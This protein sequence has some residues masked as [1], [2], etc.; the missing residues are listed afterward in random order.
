MQQPAKVLKALGDETRLRILKLLL[1][2]KF[3]VCE[4]EAALDLPQSKVSR[5]LTVL[6]SVDLAEDSRE[7]LWIFYSLFKPK[8]DFERAIFQVIENA[9]SDN[10]LIKK[11]QERLR[12]KL[13]Q[14][15]GYKCKQSK[16]RKGALCHG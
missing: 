16:S 3:C 14:V 1:K 10:H 9:L 4:L 12:R 6:R 7:G 13:S 11:D 2:G 5:H 15:Y 8:N